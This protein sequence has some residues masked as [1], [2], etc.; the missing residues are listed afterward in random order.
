M[1][2]RKEYKRD[3]LTIIWQ[4]RLC[5]HAGICVKSLP[6]VYHPGTQPWVLPE[7]ASVEQ[8]KAQIDSCPSG[9]LS[10]REE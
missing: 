5:I 8:L 6:H 9:A 2:I 4:P 1:D 3:G 10:Y 7:N